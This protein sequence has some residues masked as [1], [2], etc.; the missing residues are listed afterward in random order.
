[1]LER[2]DVNNLEIKKVHTFCSIYVVEA[3]KIG[4][5]K[6]EFMNDRTRY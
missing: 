2:W 3:F 1:M 4:E 5:G 6:I